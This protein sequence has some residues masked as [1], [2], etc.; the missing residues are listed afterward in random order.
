MDTIQLCDEID[1]AVAEASAQLGEDYHPQS[2]LQALTDTLAD[3]TEAARRT[4]H[5]GSR[6][7]TAITTSPGSVVIQAGGDI[8]GTHYS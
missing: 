8:R 6:T 5:R 1:R 4:A 7:M 2:V 3:L